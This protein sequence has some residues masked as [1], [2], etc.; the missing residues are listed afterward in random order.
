MFE[1]EDVDTR[2][3]TED[4]SRLELS[5]DET[6]GSTNVASGFNQSSPRAGIVARNA[7]NMLQKRGPAYRAHRNIWH[8]SYDSMGLINRARSSAAETIR[9]IWGDRDSGTKLGPFPRFEFDND[10]DTDQYVYVIGD[11]GYWRTHAVSHVP[12]ATRSSD[13]TLINCLFP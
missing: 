12:S 8:L 13:L 5:D 9:N 2:D 10:M 7:V 6:L 1:A 11:R 3:A 4:I